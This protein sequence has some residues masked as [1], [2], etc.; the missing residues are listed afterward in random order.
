MNQEEIKKM[1]ETLSKGN[2]KIKGDLVL[3]KHVETQIGH[4][5]EGAICVQ[6]YYGNQK[7]ETPPENAEEKAAVLLNNAVFMRVMQKAVDQ[8][9]CVQDGWR[10]QW[11]VKVEAAYFASVASQQFNLSNRRDHDGDTA[12]SWIPFEALFG[13]EKLRLSYNDYKQC[14][15]TLRRKKEIDQLFK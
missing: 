6:N 7:S 4:A 1:L 13:V 9:F 10:Y 11:K 14:K 5:E 3:E 2:I 12:I 15:T 8:G